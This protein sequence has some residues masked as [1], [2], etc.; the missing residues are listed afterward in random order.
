[1]PPPRPPYRA[2]TSTMLRRR[3]SGPSTLLTKRSANVMS[4]GI[5]FTPETMMMGSEGRRSHPLRQLRADDAGHHLIGQDEIYVLDRAIRALPPQKRQRDGVALPSQHH[6][7]KSTGISSSST[8][9]ITILCTAARSSPQARRTF[10][11]SG[12]TID[13]I[14]SPEGQQWSG[15]EY[16]ETCDAS[17]VAAKAAERDGSAILL[18]DAFADPESQPVPLVDFV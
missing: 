2:N 16:L 12:G 18:D 4:S 3:A 14:G 15:Q 11:A 13:A 7:A 9:R 5:S 10:S 6:Q 17:A 1:M 8:Q